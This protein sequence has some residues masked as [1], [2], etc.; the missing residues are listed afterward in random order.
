M[1]LKPLACPKCGSMLDRDPS[2]IT[3]PFKCPICGTTLRLRSGSY[4]FDAVLAVVSAMVVCVSLGLRGGIFVVSFIGMC[5]ALVFLWSF[6]LGFFIPAKLV[7]YE[8][9]HNSLNLFHRDR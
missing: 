9:E 2:W 6:F 5:L 8:K 3:G 4:P 1:N 7:V